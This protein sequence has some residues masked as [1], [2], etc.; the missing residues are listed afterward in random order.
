MRRKLIS[1][2][3]FVL[4]PCGR[5]QCLWGLCGLELG[6]AL[7]LQTPP[8]LQAGHLS[9]RDLGFSSLFE[10]SEVV[11]GAVMAGVVSAVFHLTHLVQWNKWAGSKCCFTV[12]E[13]ESSAISTSSVGRGTVFIY[14]LPLPLGDKCKKKERSQGRGGWGRLLCLTA[15]C[16]SPSPIFWRPTERPFPL[17][18]DKETW[19]SMAEVAQIRWRQCPLKPW[20]AQAGC[21]ACR[22]RKVSCLAGAAITCLL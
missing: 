15:A 16:R 21:V 20:G 12:A 9:G 8:G 2:C 14:R 17:V 11:C 18:S 7:G 3:R 4:W 13:S 10:A 1:R 5:V 6:T 19:S 22:V